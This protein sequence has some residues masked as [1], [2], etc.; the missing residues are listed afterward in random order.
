MCLY[1][2][3]T[4]CPKHHELNSHVKTGETKTEM[5]SS[6]GSVYTAEEETG[7]N[8]NETDESMVSEELWMWDGL[9]LDCVS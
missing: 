4:T 5:V 9:W 2:N 1:K 8:G 6:P 3:K 7:G